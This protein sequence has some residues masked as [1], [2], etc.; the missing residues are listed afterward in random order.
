MRALAVVVLVVASSLAAGVD[1]GRACSCALPD[2]REA[3]ARSDGAFVGTLESRRAA[4]QNALL[5]FRVDR[6]LK[7]SIGRRVTVVTPSNGAA[8][9]IELQIGTRAGLVLD[10]MGGAWHGSLCA[11]F[12][13]S[14]LLAAVLPLPAPNGRG[15]GALVLG[16]EC[17]DVRLL[18]LGAKRRTL[19]SGR[20]GGRSGLVSVCPGRG[21]LAEL[22]YTG[23]QTVLVI[24]RTDTLR[25]L[26]RQSVRLP[27]QRYAQRLH[28]VDPGGAQVVVFAR[29]PSGDSP[30]KSALYRVQARG[31]TA[32]WNGAAFDAAFTT[33]HA[34]LSAG[35]RGTSLVRVQLG[36]GRLGILATLPRPTA[37]LAVD[38]SG[39]LVAGV[40]T[41]PDRSSDVV[42]VDL[43][44]ARPRITTV[45]LPA[46]EGLA[47]VFWLANGRLLFVPTYGSTARVL[48]ESLRTRSRFR[49][50]AMSSALAGGRLFGTDLS[51]SLYRAA[52]PSG[53]QGV[54]RRLPGRSH[55][56]VSA[57]G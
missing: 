47:Q 23:S 4:G 35:P 40:H 24:R 19:A 21:V 9:G 32:L 51:L 38:R 46:D 27:G 25:V 31:V 45:R 30:A 6:A 53:P 22:A 57:T 48:D 10:R 15:P 13:P 14:E 7:G 11:Q 50:R 49:W 29:G 56:L 12:E 3:L 28:C 41:G 33:A 17:G 37:T 16:G 18:A 8:C 43:R 44:G 1:D 42:R 39:T 5:V 2:A 26:R 55:F 34:F 20:G 36:T 52:L 54:A